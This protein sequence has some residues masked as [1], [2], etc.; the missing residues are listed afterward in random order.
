MRISALHDHFLIP[1]FSLLVLAGSFALW[2][3][4]GRQ[5]LSLDQGWRFHLGEVASGER[6]DLSD[7]AWLALDVPHDFSITGP[8]GIDPAT[9]F[10]PFDKKSPG[11][12]GSGAL[13]A[14]IGWYRK[15]LD[16]PPSAKGKRVSIL[17]D[18]VYMD[19][20]VWLNGV[21]LGKRPFGYTGF[22]YDL[23]TH[24]KADGNVLAVRVDVRQP[25]SRWYSGAGIYR[26]VWLTIT[27][28]VH[29][30]LWGTTVTTPEVLDTYH[31]YS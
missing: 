7:A 24:L 14:G 8:P 17:F 12:T 10:G 3:G 6:P 13:N 16:I 25:C 30:A 19:S 9:M 4:E 15:S 1:L 20:E 5:T 23:S 29:V 21:S 26:H 11:T 18:G 2:A 28:P 27:D 31:S 22:Q